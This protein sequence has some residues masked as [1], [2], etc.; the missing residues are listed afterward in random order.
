MVRTSIDDGFV[1]QVVAFLEGDRKKNPVT[2]WIHYL[3][4]GSI[5][6]ILFCYFLLGRHSGG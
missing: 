4:I 5:F 1:E 3:Q 2:S 6:A